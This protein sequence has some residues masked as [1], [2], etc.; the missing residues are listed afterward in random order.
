MKNDTAVGLLA[1]AFAAVY[2]YFATEIPQSLLSDAVGADGLPKVYAIA[3]GLLSL[4]LMARSRFS[5]TGSGERAAP[6]SGVASLLP[7]LR[8]SGILVL[9]VGYLLLI[10]SLGYL[11]TIFLLITAVA[12][13]CGLK[14]NLKLIL[15]NA[16]GGVVFWV[17]FVHLFG[18]PLPSGTL[19]PRLAG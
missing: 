8:A 18:I 11:L 5:P 1:L 10:S 4:L 2:Y 12:V 16:A 13:Y 14:L 19:W 6:G 17:V 7:H 15:I 9:G 3:L